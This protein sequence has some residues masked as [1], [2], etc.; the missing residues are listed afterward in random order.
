MRFVIGFRSLFLTNGLYLLSHPAAARPGEAAMKNIAMSV[1]ICSFSLSGCSSLPNSKA[2]VRGKEI[3]GVNYIDF[4][5][6]RRGAW[7]VDEQVA[8]KVRI[9]AEPFSDTGISTEQLVTLAAKLPKDQ[10]SVDGSI[11]TISN[12]VELKGR[13]PAVLAMR[14][15]MYRMCERRLA[16][17]QGGIPADEMQIFAEIVS[18]IGAFASADRADAEAKQAVSASTMTKSTDRYSQAKEAQDSGFALLGACKWD[19]AERSF[20][21][22]ESIIPSFQVAHE[23]G[24]ALRVTAGS[25]GQR[26]AVLKVGSS[27]MSTDVEARVKKC[28]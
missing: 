22:A 1:L 19:E 16:S 9:C 21:K 2:V 14:D 6:E 28:P 17:P 27:Y 11:Q 7:V 18:I 15:V 13:T 8:G 10:G 3:P 5:S 24:R 12:L 20:A 4:P 25:G 26:D 23:Y